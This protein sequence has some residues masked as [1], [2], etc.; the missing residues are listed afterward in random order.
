[1]TFDMNYGRVDDGI[2]LFFCAVHAGV[3]ILATSQV[4]GE[5]CPGSESTA[6]MQA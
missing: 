5:N 3:R 2:K 6:R 1:M 4:F